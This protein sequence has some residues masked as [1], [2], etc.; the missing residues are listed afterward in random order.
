MCL[1]PSFDPVGLALRGKYYSV[2]FAR[3]REELINEEPDPF[4]HD[5][6]RGLSQKVN[7]APSSDQNLCL[8]DGLPAC[9]STR[10]FGVSIRLLC[11][12]TQPTLQSSFLETMKSLKKS[13]RRGSGYP[14]YL[15]ISVGGGWGGKGSPRNFRAIALQISRHHNR[16]TNSSRWEPKVRR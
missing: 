4:V 5:M 8:T 12:P 6:R 10:H 16:Q 2:G 1:L 15:H 11:C 9:L 7:G 3:Q 14:L 13:D